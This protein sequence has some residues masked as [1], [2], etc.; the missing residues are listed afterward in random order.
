VQYRSES[1]ISCGA[2]EI[3]LCNSRPFNKMKVHLQ[4]AFDLFM[5]KSKSET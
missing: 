1:L 2:L 4:K 5:L 3:T